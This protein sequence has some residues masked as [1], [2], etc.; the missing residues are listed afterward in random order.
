MK[1][2]NAIVGINF[3]KQD[4][5]LINYV[6]F[7]STKIPLKAVN[8]LFVFTAR[9]VFNALNKNKDN[10]EGEELLSSI[11]QKMDNVITPQYKKI[12]K[13][14]N[15]AEAGLFIQ[16]FYHRFN[17]HDTDLIVMGKEMGSHGSLNKIIIRHIPSQTL[18]IP[19]KS[20][21]SL[22]KIVIALDQTE[23]SK[24]ILNKAMEFCS[25]VSGAPTIT[26]LHIGHVPGHAELSEIFG[27]THQLSPYEFKK[28]YEAFL[29]DLKESFE[30]F[31]HENLKNNNG[32]NIN[33][34]FIGENRK[35]Y[36]ALLNYLKRE[37]ADFLIMGS[38]SHSLFDAVLLGS[39]AEKI[40]AKNDSV[41]MLIV[42]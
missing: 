35:P 25:L 26:I 28:V 23:Y 14:K 10:K 38:K 29:S 7:L 19:E 36:H 4:A 32:K 15:N 22:S 6:D 13:I 21:H 18:I 42:K 17:N 41:P 20:K 24:K 34:D 9:G 3:T 31:I 33:I 2:D 39:F 16:K 37:K 5:P 11:K 12:N 27:E 1:T 40:I 8:N 30:N